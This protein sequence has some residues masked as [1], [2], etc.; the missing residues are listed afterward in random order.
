MLTLIMIRNVSDRKQPEQ[1]GERT[2]TTVDPDEFYGALSRKPRRRVLYY[3]QENSAASVRELCDV[4]AEWESADRSRPT[5]RETK[6]RIRYSL[7]HND[8]PKL[9]SAGI[10]SYDPDELRVT[11]SPLPDELTAVLRLA[12]EYEARSDPP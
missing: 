6:D 12:R 1:G 4:L 11:L 10:V 9:D 3:L 2:G 5:G 7:Y 8:L